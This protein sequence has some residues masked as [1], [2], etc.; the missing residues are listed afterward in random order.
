MGYLAETGSG[1]GPDGPAGAVASD[2]VRKPG[3]DSRIQPAQLVVFRI[4][5]LR[6][7]FLVIGL[8]VPVYPGRQFR[9]PV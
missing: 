8:V 9:Q 6:R 1:G 5:Y 2:K 4:G 3:F 7:V